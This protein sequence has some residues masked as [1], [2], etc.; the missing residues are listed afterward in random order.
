MAY[1]I[2]FWGF[3]LLHHDDEVYLWQFNSN[4]IKKVFNS[5]ENVFLLILSCSSREGRIYR[6][7]TL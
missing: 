5:Q 2:L 3:S 1:F 4:Y 6:K 7:L